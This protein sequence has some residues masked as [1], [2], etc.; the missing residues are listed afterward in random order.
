MTTLIEGKIIGTLQD[1]GGRYFARF[2]PDSSPSSE[3]KLPITG[4]EFRSVKLD[5]PIKLLVSVVV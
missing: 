1:D 3:I 2:I 4:E 5:K